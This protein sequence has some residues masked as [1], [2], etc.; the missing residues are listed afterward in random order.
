MQYVLEA[1]PM[2]Y[3][4]KCGA[5]N[6]TAAEFCSSCGASLHTPSSSEWMDELGETCFGREWSG[7]AQ[8]GLLIGL[9]FGV[10]ITIAGVSMLLGEAIWRWVGPAVVIGIGVVIIYSIAKKWR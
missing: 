7:G 10:V 3:C 2:V 8:I 6:R 5:N 1:K 4:T 9:L